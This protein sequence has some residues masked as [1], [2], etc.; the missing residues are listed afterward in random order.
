MT[1]PFLLAWGAC[2]MLLAPAGRNAPAQTPAPTPAPEPAAKPP[3]TFSAGSWAV[4]LGGYIKV[5]AI[6][7]FDPIGSTDS[8]NPRTIPVDGSDGSNTR[9]HAR[10]SRV[11]LAAFG[12]V[13]GRELKLVVE[14]DFYGTSNAFRL[15]HAYG[16][17]GFLVAGQTWTTFMDE[18]NIPPTIDFET[19]L[20]QPLVRQGLVR[21]T[22]A[23]SKRT[24]LAFGIE[25]S[26]AQT[27][28]PP[29][30]A[31]KAEKPLPDLTARFRYETARAHVQLSGFLGLTRFRP[32][33]GGPMDVTIG[34]VLASARF[35]LFR[36]DSAY[37][38]FSWGPGLG[39]YRGEPSA[40][41]DASG[42][43]KAVKVTALMVGYERCWSSRWCSNAVVSPAWVETDPGEAL[44][45][46][47]RFDYIAAN[48]R[49]W[50]LENRAWAGVE[51]LHGLKEVRRG[52]RGSANRVQLA[53][54]FNIP[55]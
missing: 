33:D 3:F 10:E 37:A 4:R 40:A 9:I 13:E 34:G 38:Q 12:P 45:P 54:R 53:I 46:D 21:F 2:S 48:L 22:F 41:P 52:A 1:M 18:D 35:R 17:Y 25:E 15:R 6:H 55:G 32:L 36:R 39:R 7:D 26:D 8:F 16:Q 23:T 42:E 51:Y 43:L 5:D 47:R 14:G 50:F 11:G 31:G 30:V 27:V 19:A 20:A 28:P 44:A 24:Q 49:Y 29:D